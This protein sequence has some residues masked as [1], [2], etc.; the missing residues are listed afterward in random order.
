MACQVTIRPDFIFPK[1]RVAVFVDG[2]FWH[3]CPKHSKPSAWLKKSSMDAGGGRLNSS[4]SPL[5][6]PARGEERKAGGKGTA[7]RSSR[8]GGSSPLRTGKEFWWNKLVA[9]QRRDR[10]VNATLRRA[11]WRVV[12]IWEHELQQGT[13]RKE[14]GRGMKEGGGRKKGA[15]VQR[16]TL[17]AQRS[18]DSRQKVVEKIRKA[19]QRRFHSR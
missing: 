9:N 17:N 12:R 6:S 1:Q 11:G 4:P 3:G 8:L 16:P 10:V 7:W 19:L 5:S 15:N 14:E 18:T 13:R 2:C